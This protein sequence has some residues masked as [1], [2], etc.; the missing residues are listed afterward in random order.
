MPSQQE[1]AGMFASRGQDRSCIESTATQSSTNSRLAELQQ[2][3]R[4]PLDQYHRDLR[5]INMGRQPQRR[6]ELENDHVAT[7]I[8]QQPQVGQQTMSQ[9]SRT[10]NKARRTSQVGDNVIHTNAAVSLTAGTTS[11]RPSWADVQNF[12]DQYDLS[13]SIDNGDTDSPGLSP[14]QRTEYRTYPSMAVVDQSGHSIHQSPTIELL[15][16]ELNKDLPNAPTIPEV[17]PPDAEVWGLPIDPRKARSRHEELFFDRDAQHVLLPQELQGDQPLPHESEANRTPVHE[18]PGSLPQPTIHQRMP[19]N[20]ALL[21]SKSD[22]IRYGT[23]QQLAELDA[24]HDAE[25]IRELPGNTAVPRKAS[26]VPS[27]VIEGTTLFPVTV[28]QQQT[29]TP[30]YNFY[31]GMRNWE[32]ED[33]TEVY[34]KSL[35]EF[36]PFPLPSP[37]SARHSGGFE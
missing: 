27:E 24:W 17:E 7:D 28:E 3:Q 12:D 11:A 31:T 36:Y 6:H 1:R 35:G 5:E 25:D 14:R 10:A 4:K 19:T 32:F 37:P 23:A 34:R 9:Q 18:L 29:T 33:V 15:H 21:G 16:T 20:L 26:A 13:N 8:V 22:L 2:T 30:L